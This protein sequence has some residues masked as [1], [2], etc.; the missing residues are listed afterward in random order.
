MDGAL[1]IKH[2]I[3]RLSYLRQNA[4]FIEEEL[5]KLKLCKTTQI[6]TASLTDV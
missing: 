1:F 6:S 3:Q 4:Q 5:K 2:L